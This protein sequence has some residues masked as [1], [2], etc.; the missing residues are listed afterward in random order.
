MVEHRLIKS[1]VITVFWIIDVYD[2]EGLLRTF[3]FG[4]LSTGNKCNFYDLLSVSILEGGEQ[5]E[6]I[7][8]G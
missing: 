5:N 8:S 6:S 4:V 3:L 1:G 7:L 2:M